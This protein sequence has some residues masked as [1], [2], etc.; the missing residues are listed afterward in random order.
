[1]GLLLLG[2]ILVL[3]F[4][5]D[6]GDLAQQT[7]LWAWLLAHSSLLLRAF[8]A[9]VTA[10]VLLGGSRLW[11]EGQQLVRDRTPESRWWLYLTAHTAAFLA[12]A[13]VTELTF[14]G[15]LRADGYA[16]WW[17]L[18][19][20]A[21]GLATF[22]LWLAAVLP[23]PVWL[24]LARSSAGPLLGGAGVG[25]AA[26]SFGLATH[27]LWQPLAQATFAMVEGLLRLFTRDVVCQVDDLV[28]GTSRFSVS[29]APQCSGYEGIGLILAFLGGYL[30]VFRHHLRFPH[31]VLLF[32]L[33]VVLIWVANAVRIAALIGIGSA[34]APGVALGGFHSQAGWLAFNA[35]A[36]GFVAL[37]TKV[38]FF[39]ADPA[40]T[41][42][43]G[44]IDPTVAY[45]AP[46]LTLLTVT[47][48]AG[49]FTAGFDWL[50]P[51]RVG[52]TL[53]ALWM[54][55]Q[56]YG[57]WQWSWS[58]QAV[59]LGA[60]T[61]GLWL[62]LAPRDLLVETGMPSELAGAGVGWA[63]LWLV[64]RLIGYV[65]TVPLAEELAFRG[66]LTRRLIQADFATV[67]LGRLTWFSLVGSSV[68]F[69]LLHGRFWLGGM[70][71][72]LLFAVALQRRG[73]LADAVTAHATT[74][75]LLAAYVLTTGQWLLWS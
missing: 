38:R 70:L 3:T 19:W 67:P 16:G 64:F 42:P 28:I 2:E 35:L 32:P 33:G 54:C 50:Y 45:L 26:W 52:A 9:M 46:W 17:T 65:L 68:L 4:R 15:D 57:I 51:F 25:L 39:L 5:F 11:R 10:T 12:F 41:V 18:A 8:L 21:L 34:G 73:R 29:I 56:A 66:Y 60:V 31:V 6:A 22:G 75:A 36:L 62:L 24:A 44:A 74:N 58:W 63:T 43:R 55:R 13:R 61:F 69:G 30:C 37:T 27:Y 23:P 48:V 1:L 20:F 71:A 47:L 40:P 7:G 59:G 49:A 14:E 72:G 53:A